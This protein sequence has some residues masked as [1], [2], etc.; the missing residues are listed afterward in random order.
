MSKLSQQAEFVI[1][2]EAKFVHNLSITNQILNQP[3]PLGVGMMLNPIGM[4]GEQRYGEEL[5]ARPHVQISEMQRIC[6]EEDPSL[7]HDRMKKEKRI[8][9]NSFDKR[10]PII[11]ETGEEER[12]RTET[13]KKLYQKYSK[14][15]HSNLPC[16]TAILALFNPYDPLLT[17]TFEGYGSADPDNKPIWTEVDNVEKSDKIDRG[18]EHAQTA[19]EKQRIKDR[20]PKASEV[21]AQK[22]RQVIQ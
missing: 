4:N 22:F 6:E 7:Y 2:D 17:I 1:S 19:S 3:T 18:I 13:S 9:L 20:L 14:Q 21:H 12:D 16:K 5:K 11:L 8:K 15:L 10:A